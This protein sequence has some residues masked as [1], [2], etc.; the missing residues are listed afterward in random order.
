MLIRVERLVGSGGFAANLDKFFSNQ[1]VAQSDYLQ[2]IEQIKYGNAELVT[3][4]SEA[5]EQIG[6]RIKQLCLDALE[7][8]KQILD[9]IDL[10]FKNEIGDMLAVM[11]SH[12]IFSG[13]EMNVSDLTAAIT[14][15]QQFQNMIEN[16]A[17]A[18]AEY[19]GTIAIWEKYETLA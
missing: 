5:T 7:I 2:T 8:Y 14:L 12:R 1:A 17:V 15:F 11:D 19:G 18:T 3:Q 13:A 9:A 10:Y 16:S 4:L 6:T